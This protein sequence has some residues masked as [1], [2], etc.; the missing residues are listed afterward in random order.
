VAV[1]D[2]TITMGRATA[3]GIPLRIEAIADITRPPGKQLMESHIV[4]T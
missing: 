1:L 3:T 4:R 2:Q